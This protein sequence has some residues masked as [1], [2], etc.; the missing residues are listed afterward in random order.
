VHVL[1]YRHHAIIKPTLACRRSNLSI[2]TDRALCGYPAKDVS[3]EVPMLIAKPLCLFKLRRR[4]KQLAQPSKS[5]HPSV[6]FVIHRNPSMSA[7]VIFG[8]AIGLPC[9]SVTAGPLKA[10]AGGMSWIDGEPRA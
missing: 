4:P 3:A 5:D 7:S 10:D 1:L 9:P 8:T 6:R 2:A